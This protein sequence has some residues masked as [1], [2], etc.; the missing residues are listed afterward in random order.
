MWNGCGAFADEIVAVFQELWSSRGCK[1]LHNWHSYSLIV[2]DLPDDGAQ[3]TLFKFIVISLILDRPFK[4]FLLL[5]VEKSPYHPNVSITGGGI[6][7]NSS[8]PRTSLNSRIDK[9]IQH[10]SRH[11]SRQI[12]QLVTP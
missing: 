2:V 6:V 9:N 10:P 1:D 12:F 4:Q 8:H 11:R 7:P 3:R 5:I